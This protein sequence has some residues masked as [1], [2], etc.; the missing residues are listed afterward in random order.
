MKLFHLVREADPSGVSGT[1]V[2]AEV[3][4]FENGCVAV[5]FFADRGPGVSALAVYR[6]LSDA[7][8]I[9]GHGG[10]TKLVAA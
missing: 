6:C 1:G 3:V 10:L 9:H 8:V 2:V 7:E 5:A 4:E